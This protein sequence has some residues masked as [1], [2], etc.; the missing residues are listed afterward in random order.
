[1]VTGY[2]LV[3]CEV[4][5]VLDAV[6]ELDG[7]DGV[8]DVNPVTGKYDVIAEIEVDEIDR[9]RGLVAGRFHDTE[10]VVDTKTCIST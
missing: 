1:M 3:R 10:G 4:D 8:V 9:L 7:V 5:S 2:V 6:D